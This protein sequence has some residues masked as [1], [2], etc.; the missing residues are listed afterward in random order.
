VRLWLLF[1]QESTSKSNNNSNNNNENDDRN[2]TTSPQSSDVSS[3]KVSKS[4]Q[5][6][7]EDFQTDEYDA[8]IDSYG[9]IQ[10][11]ENHPFDKKKAACCFCYETYASHCER[12]TLI[13]LH[14]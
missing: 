10:I 7:N 13:L 5:F 3:S 8:V 1:V 4:N 14:Y 6:E 9:Q 11:L 12:K 2:M